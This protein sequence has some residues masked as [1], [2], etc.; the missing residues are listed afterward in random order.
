MFPE[1]PVIVP[2]VVAIATDEKVSTGTH[3]FPDRTLP[4]PVPKYGQ[5]LT[6][7]VGRR[8]PNGED[9]GSTEAELKSKMEKLLVVF[10]NGDDTGMASRLFK[11]FLAKQSQVTYFDDPDL[12]AAA[13][14]H[15]NIDHFCRAAWGGPSATRGIPPDPGTTRIHQA[16]KAANWDINK[17]V[18]P[19]DLDPPAFDRGSLF[20]RTKDWNNGLHLMI[21]GV[22]HVYVIATHYVYNKDLSTYLICLTY[23]FYDVFGLDDDDLKEYGTDNTHWYETVFGSMWDQWARPGITAWWQLQHQHAYAPLVTRIVLQRT[24]MGFSTP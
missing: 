9:V 4:V 5:D 7:G 21:N 1:L 24:F 2:K 12:T 17:L 19:T 15:K 10:A 8:A 23:V 6:F 18:A 20:W 3:P 13:D 14:D 22:Q 16:L 11:R